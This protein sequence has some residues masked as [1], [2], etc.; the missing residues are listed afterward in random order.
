MFFFFLKEGASKN[1]FSQFLYNRI[2][3]VLH[4]A[5]RK[6]IKTGEKKDEGRKKGKKG[7]GGKHRLG[8]Q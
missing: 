5:I 2:L 1:S 8:K 3:K 4:S 6:R 7:K